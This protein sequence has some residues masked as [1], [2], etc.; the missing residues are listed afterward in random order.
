MITGIKN[1]EQLRAE[2]FRILN[3]MDITVQLLKDDVENIKGSLNPL[4]MV[5]GFFKNMLFNQHAGIMHDSVRTMV[6]SFS[7]DKL[8]GFL[9]WPMRIAA[10]YILKNV[11]S[12]FIQDKKGTIMDKA[13]SIVGGFKN[14]LK[15]SSTKTEPS[16]ERATA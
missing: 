4:K 3:E 6:G 9:P 14:M 13:L 10:S 16:N 8:L 11:V 7:Y 15:K 2:R 1:L 12:N 5:T